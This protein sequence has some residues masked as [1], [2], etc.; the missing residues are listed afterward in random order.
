M[1]FNLIWE[2]RLHFRKRWG[3]L[4]LPVNP[5]L[6]VEY[7]V[8][9]R[10]QCQTEIKFIFTG[11]VKML[12]WKEKVS[13]N[14]GTKFCFEYLRS[15][16]TRLHGRRTEMGKGAWSTKKG[17]G[18]ESP[19]Q[20]VALVWPPCYT[21]LNEVWFLSNIVFNIV[22]HLFCSQQWTTML[23]RATLSNKV[24]WCCNCLVRP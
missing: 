19:N 12:K 13:C 6:M 14:F 17:K 8:L 4:I 16:W 10:T 18:K 3:H 24:G 1:L 5:C 7:V 22:Q 21:M 11:N 15:V 20:H 23:H 2:T 9:S